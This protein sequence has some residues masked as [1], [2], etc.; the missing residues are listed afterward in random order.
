MA[1]YKRGRTYYYQFQFN[2]ERIQESAHTRNKEVAR[3]IEA[4]HRVR[5]AKGEAGI[6][7]RPP[8]PT[9][10]DFAPRFK[11]AVKTLCANKHGTID[12]YNSKL[13]A[14]LRY[15]P[16]ASARL[17]AIQE[18]V[19]Q[20][21]TEHRRWQPSRKKTPM[22][23]ASVNREL[24]TLRRALRLAHEWKLIDRVPRI[25]L[26]SGEEAREF[27]LSYAQ[28]KLYLEMAPVLL[29]D[30]GILMLDTGLRVGE[31]ITLEWPEVHL[32][33][34]PD[35]SL[36][37][38]KVRARHSKNS[39]PR[40]IPL[41][42]RAVAVLESR[43]PAKAGYVFHRDD[44]RPVY[45]TWLN[46]Q[47]SDLRIRLKMPAEFVP[48]SFRHTYGT[49]LGESG[50]DAFTIMRL[51]GHSSITVSQKYVH[52]SPETMERAVVRLDR[53]NRAKT[54]P[55]PVDSLQKSLQSSGDKTVM[56]S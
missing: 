27:V 8:K 38:L 48:H 33:P 30:M 34:A 14:L 12:F 18:A 47:H 21:F 9:F 29:H 52:P 36:G 43:G 23:I 32:T 4:A 15:E 40:N 49:R 35:A 37:Y 2:G 24:A 42:E 11:E 10:R 16:I 55:E 54:S 20:A 51:M 45:Q 31:A 41:T 3:Q 56:P 7:E 44:G 6:T 13:E 19:I 46:Q 28:E 5:L 1:I 53:M 50:A 25:R 17:D 22:S 26:L 39:K